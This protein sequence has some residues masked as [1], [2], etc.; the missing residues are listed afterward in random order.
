MDVQ[1]QVA[2]EL[3]C[4]VVSICSSAYE[5]KR[6]AL[7]A[8]GKIREITDF[9]SLDAAAKA[10][11]QVK[12]LIDVVEASRKLVKEPILK[13]GKQI[14]ELA[15]SYSA[16]LKEEAERLSAITGAYQE[17]EKRKTERIR[18]EAIEKERQLLE[19]LNAYQAERIQKGGEGYEIAADLDA[20]QGMTADKIAETRIKLSNA[21]GPKPAGL[22]AR[23]NWKFEVTNIQTLYRS[24]PELCV[25]S[26]NN[27]AINAVIKN[28]QN[29]PGLRIWRET[30]AVVR[31]KPLTAVTYDY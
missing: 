26:P 1:I 25:I 19:E 18:Q 27:A 21:I 16:D 7:T 15:K 6:A 8:A 20:M 17:A 12:G 23:E 24:H 31:S 30:K 28:N 2:G 14:D 4:P 9:N 11:G 10:L 22:S 13:A 3:T 29:L 5:A